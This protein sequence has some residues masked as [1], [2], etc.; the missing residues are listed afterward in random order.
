M[1]APNGRPA[2][3]NQTTTAITLIANANRSTSVSV[4]LSGAGSSIGR[5]GRVRRE[6]ASR[7]EL[8]ERM[9][10]TKASMS[11][12]V[13]THVMASDE[14]TPEMIVRML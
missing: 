4:R 3:N 10:H 7:A 12:D 9:G 2:R 1:T 11:V 6:L 8:A 5:R 14:I 13:Y